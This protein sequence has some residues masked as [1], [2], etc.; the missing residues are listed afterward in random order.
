MTNIG[1]SYTAPNT[2]DR[3]PAPRT[4]YTN[5]S[6]ANR[7][8]QQSIQFS[9]TPRVKLQGFSFNVPV[10]VTNQNLQ[11]PGN[12]H[13]IIGFVA[14]FDSTTVPGFNIA[15]TITLNNTVLYNAIDLQ[16]FS[17]TR[18]NYAEGWMPA[19]EPVSG[20]DILTLSFNNGTATGVT[21]C[22]FILV[23]I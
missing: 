7:K 17:C 23:Y 12:A 16:M 18:L 2:A 6:P 8:I 14:S 22:N 20:Q 10:G 9:K 1:R 11:V 15:T 4:P 13:T 5:I 3:A 19:C 21:P